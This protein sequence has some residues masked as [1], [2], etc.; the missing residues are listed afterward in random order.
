M[1]HAPALSPA[2]S[3]PAS[4]DATVATAQPT[5]EAKPVTPD[6]SCS[7]GSQTASIQPFQPAGSDDVRQ[8][9]TPAPRS[10]T[11]PGGHSPGL[12]LRALARRMCTSSLGASN[13]LSASAPGAYKER[14]WGCLASL[15]PGAGPA[16]ASRS[17][18]R[19]NLH[20]T[21]HPRRT[22][23]SL[24]QPSTPQVVYQARTA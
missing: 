13:T 22:S 3:Q 7:P 19:R 24:G 18:P 4:S 14:L 11:H 10:D 21:P 1:H 23:S 12:V 20:T 5:G 2:A 15:N 17:P 16:A 9:V 6:C 8:T